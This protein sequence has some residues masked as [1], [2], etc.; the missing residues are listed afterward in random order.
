[1]AATH[2]TG[3]NRSVTERGFTNY[4]EFTDTYRA[5]ITVRQSSAATQDCVWVFTD[6]GDV[7]PQDGSR[8]NRGSAHLDVEGARRLRDAL[9]AFIA[10]HP[11]S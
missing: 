8:L 7:E 11:E 5:T 6:G 3:P 4:D 9:D 2:G 1:M 10:E